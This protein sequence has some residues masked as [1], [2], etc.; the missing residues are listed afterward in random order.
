MNETYLNYAKRLMDKE[1]LTK[2]ELI[3]VSLLASIA[4]SLVYLTKQSQSKET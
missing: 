3:Q 1:L 4:E 2:A